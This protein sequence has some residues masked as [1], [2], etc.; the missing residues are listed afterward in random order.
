LENGKFEV[1][2]KVGLKVKFLLAYSLGVSQ[3][4]LGVSKTCPTVEVSSCLP[5]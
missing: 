5:Y 2:I 3:E 1:I 4:A